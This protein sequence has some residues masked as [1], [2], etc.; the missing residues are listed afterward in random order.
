MILLQYHHSIM[1]SIS[2]F[3]SATPEW[4]DAAPDLIVHCWRLLRLKQA[5]L[6]CEMNHWICISCKEFMLR[7]EKAASDYLYCFDIF[8]SL[9]TGLNKKSTINLFQEHCSLFP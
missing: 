8:T 5:G 1:N 7:V 4:F 3:F 6:N 9:C 2:S